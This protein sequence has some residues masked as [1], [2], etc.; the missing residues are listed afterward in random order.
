ME[1]EIKTVINEEYIKRC[2]GN[3]FKLPEDLNGKKITLRK[4]VA[5][6]IEN[7]I[8][9]IDKRIWYFEGNHPSSWGYNFDSIKLNDNDAHIK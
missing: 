1:N 9:R 2:A 5:S 4:I 7:Y 6:S 8:N 3:D